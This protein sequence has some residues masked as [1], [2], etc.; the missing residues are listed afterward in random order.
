MNM[1]AQKKKNLSISGF[2]GFLH[3][4]NINAILK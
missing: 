3:F 1:K 4:Y 2:A